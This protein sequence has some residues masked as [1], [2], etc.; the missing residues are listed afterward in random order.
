[1]PLPNRTRRLH[2]IGTAALDAKRLAEQ[3]FIVMSP[4]LSILPWPRSTSAA[5]PRASPIVANPIPIVG[6]LETIDGV[7]DQ[8]AARCRRTPCTQDRRAA[9]ASWCR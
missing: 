6:V 2:A 4:R 7:A 3:A 9:A 1:M 5:S 8:K